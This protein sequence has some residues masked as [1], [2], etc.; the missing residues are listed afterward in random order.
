[1]ATGGGRVLTSDAVHFYE[2]FELDRPFG[3]V[4]DLG[5]MYGAYDRIKELGA[6][7]GYSF[8]PA[9]T[10]VM[11]R[12]PGVGGQRADSPC[13]VGAP[14]DQIRAARG[15]EARDEG[16]MRSWGVGG[17]AG[18]VALARR[19]GTASGGVGPAGEDPGRVDRGHHGRLRHHR[20][21]HG[22]RGK[23]AVAKVNERGGILGKSSSSNYNDK[24]DDA[25]V[26]ALPAPRQ[27]R[28]GRSPRLGRHRTGHGRDGR[29]A[30]VPNTGAV[31][32][33]GLTIYPD[34]PT[35]RRTNGY[36]AWASTLRMG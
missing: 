13:A 3:V 10:Q 18:V 7:P 25:V 1:M 30:H 34:G 29:A 17:G 35:A 4:A 32:D 22:E 11:E 21:R 26:P 2:E 5:A 15:Q 19:G 24:A 12:F 6:G 14:G 28:R 20:H 31:D 8:V 27:R 9:T 16:Q 36:S 33:A 23:L